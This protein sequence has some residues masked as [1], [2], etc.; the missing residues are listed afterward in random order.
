MRATIALAVAACLLLL[1][2]CGTSGRQKQAKA[3]EAQVSDTIAA[4][5]HDLLTRNWTDI[6]ERLFSAQARAQAGEANCPG[7][8]AAGA[9][10]LRGERIEVRSVV[11]SG[12]NASAHVMTTAVGQAPVAETIGLVLEQGRYRINALAR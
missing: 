1:V 10:G 2:A 11:V 12:A 3:P 9:A 7:F 6:C 4:L 5:Q 8:V